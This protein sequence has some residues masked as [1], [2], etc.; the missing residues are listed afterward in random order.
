MG[1]VLICI[2]LDNLAVFVLILSMQEHGKSSSLLVSPSN[3]FFNVLK[4][5][6][7]RPLTFQFGLYAGVL[8]L[9]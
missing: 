1:I 5:P 4:F 9:L 2:A 7:F 8:D 3:P 6:L